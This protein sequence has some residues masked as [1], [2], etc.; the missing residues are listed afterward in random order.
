MEVPSQVRDHWQL[1]PI[2]TDGKQPL[3][4]GGKGWVNARP[5]FLWEEWENMYSR[6]NIAVCCARS[7]LVVVDIDPAGQAQWLALIEHHGDPVTL[8]AATGRGEHYFFKMRKDAHYRGKLG[9]GIDIKWNGY[10]LIEPS[11]HAKTGK[12]YKFINDLEPV[13]PPEWLARIIEKPVRVERREFEGDHGILLPV[14]EGMRA[15]AYDYAEWLTVGQ[16]LHGAFEGD[17]RGLDLWVL[18]SKNKSEGAEDEA[19]C[20]AKWET[21]SADGAV[22]LGSLF[23]LAKQKGVTIPNPSLS[24]DK[25][26]FAIDAQQRKGEEL[27]RDWWDED[28]KSVTASVREAVKFFNDSGYGVYEHS[29][30]IVREARHDGVKVAKFMEV[31]GFNTVHASR[32]VKFY[33]ATGEVTYKKATEVWLTHTERTT[34]SRIAFNHKPVPGALNLWS[35]IPCTPKA[36][37]CDAI[38]EFIKNVI[39]KGDAG[40]NTWLIQW[41][42]HLCQK[43]EQKST[44]VPVIIGGQG[45]GKGLF[46]DGILA[47]IFGPLYLLIDKSNTIGE[48]F[49][50]EQSKRLI[51]VLDEATWGQNYQLS[52]VLKR[53]TGNDTMQ[54]EAKFGERYTI[55][56]YSRYIV[57]S[58]DVDA[59]RIEPGNRRYLVLESAQ[60]RSIAYYEALWDKIREKSIVQAFYAYLLKID[61]TGF[62]PW[63][64]PAEL[65]NEGEATKVA[66]LRP[67]EKF[68]FELMFERPMQLW[69]AYNFVSRD[70]F[71]SAY[72]QWEQKP[73]NATVFRRE[74]LKAIPSLDDFQ[75]RSRQFGRGYALTPTELRTELGKR[76]RIGIECEF[77]DG[78]Y[79]RGVD[80]DF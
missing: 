4:K 8:R 63:R 79:M 70:A 20:A 7:G 74:M 46:T 54:V 41:L 48:R 2:S 47:G 19:A 11:V 27:K 80:L 37:N 53:L 55:E 56:N 16:A 66:S 10:C 40:K 43:P 33:D 49:N 57:T 72:R 61:L 58:N 67:V 71:Y 28:G 5:F 35:N 42:A 31:P 12:P 21:F 65:D 15:H 64:F 75:S 62:S 29:G 6:N 30:K 24:L 45:S 60:P 14:I 13:E 78:E 3:V 18:F 73:V 32:Q 34:Y 9:E 69:D 44:L 59:V 22:T 77:A 25:V 38:L 23:H 76:L 50:E 17:E 68:I 1:I 36:G 39:C 26:A 51:T 52:N